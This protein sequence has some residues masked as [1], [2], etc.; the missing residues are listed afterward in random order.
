MKQ[1]MK[2]A[3][4][5]SALVEVVLAITILGLVSAPICSSLMVAARINARSRAVMT[6]QMQVSSA[7]EYLMA[8]G[9]EEKEVSGTMRPMDPNLPGVKVVIDEN[10]YA[11]SAYC[12]ITVSSEDELVSVDTYVKV[13]EEQSEPDEPTDEPGGGT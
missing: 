10:E 2:K 9:I 6:A 4:A 5:G 3:T 13:V 7:V 11:E 1:W 8:K 12:R